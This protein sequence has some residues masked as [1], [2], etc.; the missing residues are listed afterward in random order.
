MRI[1]LVARTFSKGGAASGARNL[2]AALE[3]VGSDVVVVD[4]TRKAK[5][6]GR[7]AVRVA[8]RIVE[9]ALFGAECHC[10]KLGPASV[11]LTRMVMDHDPDVVQL[12]DVSWNAISFGD[13][14]SVEVPVIHRMSDMWPYGGPYHYMPSSSRVGGFARLSTGLF[15][16]TVKRNDGMPD[17]LTAPS[18]W[19][20]DRVR[21]V[22]PS[23]TCIEVVRNAT[24]LSDGLG[25]A[26][27]PL[28]RT[29]RLGFISGSVTQHRKGFDLLA[30]LL[31]GSRMSAEWNVLQV[32]GR[33]GRGA[34]K[35]A[36]RRIT[37][38]YHGPYGS[39][40]VD[41]VY[42]NVDVLLCPSRLDNSP[43]V[44]CEALVRGIPVIGQ[45][46]TGMNSYIVHGSTGFLFDFADSSPENIEVLESYLADVAANYTSFSERASAY[47]RDHLSLSKIGRAYVDLYNRLLGTNTA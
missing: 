32:F 17:L 6:S 15:N 31:D 33:A 36:P 44:V 4:A 11:D 38:N 42:R 8:E 22:V 16:A 40:D 46:D 19:L 41:S 21:S 3:K 26:R 28:H 18:Q 29:L 34:A 14:F 30:P 20:A 24:Y 5:E 10:L 47:A 45:I 13:L 23:Q 43:N 39:G 2:L 35:Y 27:G 12:C 9:K 37:V 25:Q 1:L 7:L